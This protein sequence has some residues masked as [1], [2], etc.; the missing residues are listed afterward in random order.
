MATT[1]TKSLDARL[2]RI[3]RPQIR[4]FAV[5]PV[6]QSRNELLVVGKVAYLHSL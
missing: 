6:R 1:P 3:T 5:M 2:H 4:P